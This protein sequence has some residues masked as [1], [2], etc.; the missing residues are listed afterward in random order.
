MKQRGRYVVLV[1]GEYWVPIDT[2]YLAWITSIGW[3]TLSHARMN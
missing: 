2:Q 3:Q 1:T